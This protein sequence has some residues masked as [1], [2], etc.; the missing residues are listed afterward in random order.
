[1]SDRLFLLMER[2][3]KLDDTLRRI[4]ARRWVDPLEIARLKKLKLALKDR[5]ARLTLRPR[6]REA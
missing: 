3:Q 2:H 6:R 1:M 4:Q 5:L